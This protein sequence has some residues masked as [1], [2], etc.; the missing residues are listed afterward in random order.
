MMSDYSRTQELVAAAYDSE[1][2]SQKQFEKT[3]DSLDAKLTQLKNAWDS[4]TMG[5]ANNEVIKLVVDTLTLILNIFNK[6]TDAFG[7]GTSSVMKLV[8]AFALFS[9]LSKTLPK[10]VSKIAKSVVQ[11]LGGSGNEAGTQFVNNTK[12]TIINRL[13]DFFNA[14]KAAGQATAQGYNSGANSQNNAT[15]D[16]KKI[17]GLKTEVPENGS[18]NDGVQGGTTDL[19]QRLNQLDTYLAT[20]NNAFTNASNAV[21]K[22]ST[23]IGIVG[24]AISGITSYIRGQN[25][26]LTNA[27]EGALSFFETLST[28]ATII[29]SVATALKALGLTS[30]A[31][32]VGLAIGVITALIAVYKA[33]DA[34]YEDAEERAERLNEEYEEQKQL[35]NEI[36]DAYKGYDNAVDK[37]DNL[38][39]G[40]EEYTQ[41]LKEATE[42]AQEI[43]NLSGGQVKLN[44][45]PKGYFEVDTESYN[46]WVEGEKNK[47]ETLQRQDLIAQGI[48][49]SNKL[50]KFRLRGGIK[51]D[52]LAEDIETITSYVPEQLDAVNDLKIIKELRTA[53]N[54]L[55]NG[56]KART[57]AQS[58]GYDSADELFSAL[59]RKYGL[60]G[61]YSE[62]ATSDNLFSLYNELVWGVNEAVR[63]TSSMVS[64]DRQVLGLDEKTAVYV[65]DPTTL[66]SSQM[67]D[68]KKKGTITEDNL[69][70]FYTQEQIDDYIAQGVSREALAENANTLIQEAKDN[71]AHFYTDQ[72]SEDYVGGLAETFKDFTTGELLQVKEQKESLQKTDEVAKKNGNVKSNVEQQ[73]DTILNDLVNTDEYDHYLTDAQKEMVRNLLEATDFTDKTQVEA[74]NTALED[75]GITCPALQSALVSLSSDVLAAGY[76]IRKSFN[77]DAETL[78]ENRATVRE[79]AEA[80]DINWTREEYESLIK[81]AKEV[82]PAAAAAM[83]QMFVRNGKDSF[84]FVGDYDELIAKNNVV[85]ERSQKNAEEVINQNI[86]AQEAA[87]NTYTGQAIITESNGEITADYLKGRYDDAAAKNE[88]QV[89]LDSAG[90][91]DLVFDNMYGEGA[92][93][94]FIAGDAKDWDNDTAE[95]FYSIYADILSNSFTEKKD[96]LDTSIPFYGLTTS[97]I[98]ASGY[99]AGTQE[100]IDR[101]NALLDRY[102]NSEYAS[103]YYSDIADDDAVEEFKDNETAIKGLATVA[104]DTAEKFFDLNSAI[105]ENYDT[106]KEGKKET[107]AYKRSMASLKKAMS[108]AFGG[109]EFDDDFIIENL[110]DIKLAADGDSE[111]FVRLQQTL[112]DLG[113]D[114]WAE[115]L[116]TNA[117]TLQSQMDKVFGHDWDTQATMDATPFLNSLSL[118]KGETAEF[119]KMLQESGYKLEWVPIGEDSQGIM[120]YKGIILNTGRSAIRG[121]SGG[122]GGGGGGGGSDKNWE[123][124]YDPLYNLTE[125]INEALREREKLEREYD[126]LLEDRNGNFLDIIK[127]TLDT[128]AN[129]EEEIALQQR[130]QEGRRAQLENIG[131]ETFYDSDGNKKTFSEAG[132]MQYASYDFGTQ[133]I[134]ID[135]SAIDAITDTDKGEAVEAYIGRLE[136]LQEQFEDTQETLEEMQDELEEIKERGKEEYLDFEQKVYDAIVERQ[137]Q[138]IDDFQD[139]SDDINDANSKILDDLQKSIE[140][141]RQIRDNTETEEDIADKEARLAY[142]QRDTSGANASEILRLQQEIE[143][144]RQDYQDTLI[145][146]EL[147]RLNDVNETANE[148]RERQIEIMQSQLDWDE[149]NGAFWEETYGLIQGALNEDGSFNRNSD[150]VKLLAATDA[151]KGMSDFGKLNWIGELIQQFNEAQ[152]GYSNWMVDRVSEEGTKINAVD[153]QGNSVEL[154]YENGK[155]TQGDD[156]YSV[157]YDATSKSYVAKKNEKAKTIEEYTQGTGTATTTKK[158]T[159]GSSNSEDKKGHYTADYFSYYF[160]SNTGKIKSNKGTSFSI[161][162]Q[163]D[164]NTRAQKAET[165]THNKAK[166]AYLLWKIDNGD[167]NLSFGG[168]GKVV[169]TAYFAYA[170]GGLNTKTGPAWLD[171]T[172]S[173]PEYVLNATQ[174]EAF[175]KLTKVLPDLLG[176]NSTTTTRGG[177][178]YYDVKFIVDEMSSD[179]DVDQLWERFKQ[180]I[181][182]DGSYRN[183]TVINRLR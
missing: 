14:G 181:Y 124:P 4:F 35:L 41:A 53:V 78:G 179:Y 1:G 166:E 108:N 183:T 7:S 65:Q 149:K 61:D 31:G 130:L 77:F 175:L 33:W 49:K 106:L 126:R 20:N 46:N 52:F 71:Y 87:K 39:R 75:L 42:Y 25:F 171:G 70:D 69:L 174:T 109:Q 64:E 10:L 68:M 176:G 17:S 135:W 82:D 128:M 66:T 178:T 158:S 45:N 40:T 60:S 91:S 67:S 150:L 86:D 101:Q 138:L 111:A 102:N 94:K 100:E 37:L 129:L 144:A 29:S 110:E 55:D 140:L 28:G 27:E 83:E 159:S 145:D 157:E 117:Q 182:E 143:D 36:S 139:L 170:T 16:L 160:D 118:A 50:N 103:G 26:E 152:Q 155:W 164:A 132:V 165:D 168:G 93:K 134:T 11:G 122:S 5:L 99:G 22:Y 172:P 146:Q 133:T 8:A 48:V 3:L 125:K 112:F 9:G 127:N 142:L 44:W 73:F 84:G 63:S 81:Q 79:K 148:Q 162:S 116:G 2:S 76:A 21:T 137:Q 167:T 90:I 123:N 18:A 115:T 57:Y 180:K 92:Y 23:A 59:T 104:A 114:N 141:Q 13:D 156:T 54:A 98:L 153:A 12:K 97:E 30:L 38:T 47:E 113:K 119:E 51:S 80:G 161:I 43:S 136:E 107:D 163:D 56:D 34:A 88:L 74:L 95:E 151:F 147:D 131:S 120:Q 177:D 32:P 58:L 24:L 89:I 6:V 105:S 121:S 62:H 15:L 19:G 85:E 173:K 169:S 154:T 96:V 72:S